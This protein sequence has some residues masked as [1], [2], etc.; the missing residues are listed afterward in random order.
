MSSKRERRRRSYKT[1]TPAARSCIKDFQ[2]AVQ[3]LP[4]PDETCT[5]AE[6]IDRIGYSTCYRFR[7]AGVIEKRRDVQFDS[8]YDTS[9]Y[10]WS[11][12]EHVHKWAREHTD[13]ENLTPCGSATGIRCVEAGEVYTCTADHCDCEMT[14]EEALEVVE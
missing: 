9:G 10:L 12:P 6:L 5:L 11:V 3:Q 8:D 2:P 13:V 1:P 14:R 4:D 7:A